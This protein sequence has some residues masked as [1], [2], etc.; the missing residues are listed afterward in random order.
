[1]QAAG[2]RRSRAARGALVAA[3]AGV[4]LLSGCADGE[5]AREAQQSPLPLAGTWRAGLFVQGYGPQGLAPSATA[6][7]SASGS[8]S[9]S[10]SSDPS[11]TDP[12]QR[13]LAPLGLVAADVTNGYRVDLAPRGTSLMEKTLAFCGKDYPSEEAR[14]A[15][16]RSV[17]VAP[18]G[19]QPGVLTE[20]VL[21]TTP[22]AA[23]AALDELRAAT[24]ACDP[25]A[26]LDTDGDGT[27]VTIT[28]TGT[29]GVD[30]RGFVPP[31]DRVLIATTLTETKTKATATFI[32]LYQVRGRVL[33]ALYL[34]HADGSAFSAQDIGDL[35]AL[36]VGI[37]KRLASLDA[38]VADGGP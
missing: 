34:Q 20:A 12:Q 11:L 10:A 4:V 36:G 23:A 16:R 38:A 28:Q 6:S 15:R 33:V 17:V 21:Y 29:D 35:H 26:P 25:A 3:V 18:D 13:I 2:V 5:R 24:R 19:S 7:P 22:K 31:S 14:E 27:A 32:T 30:V 9:G 37:A 8:A 1:M